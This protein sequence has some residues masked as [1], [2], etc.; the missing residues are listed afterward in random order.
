MSQ[1]QAAAQQVDQALDRLEAVLKQ[2]IA[3]AAEADVHL[4]RELASL[5]VENQ[6]MRETTG[7]ALACVDAAI[8]RLRKVLGD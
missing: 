7:G 3:P 1:L 4:Q 6:A 8:D 5:Q 2:H